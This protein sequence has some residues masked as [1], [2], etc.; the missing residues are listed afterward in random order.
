MANWTHRIRL[1]HL[2][3]LLRLCETR[4]LSKVAGELN[5]T[6]PALSKWLKDL[7]GDLGVPLF[8][9]QARGIAP[10][11]AALELAE[12]A[13]GILGRLDRAQAA[14]EQSARGASG[15]LAVGF[16]PVVAP[17]LLPASIRHFR[18]AYPR[19]VVQIVEGTLDHLL[20]RLHD[21][22]FDIV[23]GRLEER[24]FPGG[25]KCA[26]LY[27]EPVCLSVGRSHPLARARKVGWADVRAYPWISPEPSTPLRIRLDYELALA[28][29]SHPWHQIESSSVQTNVAL[30]SGSDLIAPMSRRLA[31]HFQRQGLL[32]I[33]PLDMSSRGAIGM[34]WR[35]DATRSEHLQYFIDSLRH[36]VG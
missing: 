35:E 12:H 11:A 16:S 28:G 30:L 19:V 18:A 27:D 32:K 34:M 7:E 6:Q 33:L 5:I 25:L 36:A 10:T 31:E 8:L 20:P 14:M 13:R 15:Y 3:L 26:A 24:T 4:N 17:V 2:E 23:V 1:R 9:R 29:E 21:G 22:H